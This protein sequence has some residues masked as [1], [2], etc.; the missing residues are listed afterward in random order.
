[1]SGRTLARLG[2]V[3]RSVRRPRRHVPRRRSFC[4]CHNTPTNFSSRERLY[5]AR[6]TLGPRLHDGRANG[7]S[8][9]TT[10][11]SSRS[12]QLA[13][14]IFRRTSAYASGPLR[15]QAIERFHMLTHL[16]YSF[17]PVPG[18]RSAPRNM[19]SWQMPPRDFLL[20]GQSY[21]IDLTA[22]D[23]LQNAPGRPLRR[24]CRKYTRST[25]R[26]SQAAAIP[27]VAQW[28]NSL[29]PTAVVHCLRNSICR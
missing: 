1:M 18:N 29:C 23:A 11:I 10:G 26:A 3:A 14:T 22:I 24:L 20:H 27:V 2:A 16:Q 12:L 21:S 9:V 6:H 4:S 7:H 5:R 25:D 15:A 8:C 19:R 13:V 17:N 28:V